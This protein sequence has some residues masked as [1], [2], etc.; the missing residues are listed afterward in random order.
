MRRIFRN[1]SLPGAAGL[2]ALAFAAPAF[3]EQCVYSDG[4]SGIGPCVQ[5]ENGTLFYSYDLYCQQGPTP[6]SQK[7]IIRSGDSFTCRVTNRG[8]QAASTNFNNNWESRSYVCGPTSTQKQKFRLSSGGGAGFWTRT[9][10][11]TQ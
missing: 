11:D 1:L 4:T 5:Y 2:L 3:A 7:I 6:S 8:Q 10:H 9:C